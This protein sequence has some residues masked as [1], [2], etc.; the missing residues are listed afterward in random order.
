MK[1]SLKGSS[2]GETNRW[3]LILS[4]LSLF[5]IIIVGLN[6]DFT[7]FVT[8]IFAFVNKLDNSFFEEAH[9]QKPMN[10]ELFRIR[11]YCS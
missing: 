4:Y 10:Y 1:F 3:A 9:A 11:E 2:T 8:I 7:Q 6:D 5:V